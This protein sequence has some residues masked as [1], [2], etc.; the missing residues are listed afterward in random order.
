VQ[1]TE[2]AG[3]THVPA[4]QLPAMGHAF[5]HLPQFEKS[6]VVS[7]QIPPQSV[8]PLGHPHAPA[9]HDF[10]EGHEFVHEPQWAASC[11]MSTHTPL[12]ML[13]PVGQVQLPETHASPPPHTLLQEP[14]CEGSLCRFT[15]P[16][17]P[18][19]VNP[20]GQTPPSPGGMNVSMGASGFASPVSPPCTIESTVA[21]PPPSSSKV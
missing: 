3:H 10:P 15:H 16:A 6:F 21:S 8:S 9:T 18:Q 4:L 5:P 11:W 2:P 19:L 12:Q 17:G 20:V 1:V 7:T 13:H 14:Q